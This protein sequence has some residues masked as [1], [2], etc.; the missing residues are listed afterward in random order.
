MNT[1]SLGI[2]ALFLEGQYVNMQYKYPMWYK[3]ATSKTFHLLLDRKKY[4]ELALNLSRLTAGNSKS[5]QMGY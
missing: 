3:Y 4:L 1:L 2:D 5:N